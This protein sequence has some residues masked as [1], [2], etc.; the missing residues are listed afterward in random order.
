MNLIFIDN[1]KSIV[2]KVKALGINARYGDYFQESLKIPRHVLVSASNPNF[3][4]GGGI[5]KD[6]QYNFPLYCE[7]KQKRPFVGNERIGNV[8]FTIT[9]DSRLDSN[10]ELVR[11]ALK[12]AFENTD[13]DETLCLIGLGTGIGYL[14]E[15][16]FI[17][18]LEEVCKNQ[19]IS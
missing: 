7:Y 5:D 2:D 1:R 13:K 8:I 16:K 14:H 18:L 11:E 17:K 9:V 10:E 4:F 12:F 19:Q 6:L 15:D 3:T